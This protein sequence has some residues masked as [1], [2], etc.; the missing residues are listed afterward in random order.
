MIEAEPSS[1]STVSEEKLAHL[2]QLGFIH[3]LDK[4]RKAE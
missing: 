3:K 2:D 1:T 4:K